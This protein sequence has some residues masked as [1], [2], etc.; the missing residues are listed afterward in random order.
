MAQE[1]YVGGGKYILGKKLGGG[2]FGEIYLGT[3]KHTR[4]FVGVKLVRM[5]PYPALGVQK[6]LQAS[7]AQLRIQDHEAAGRK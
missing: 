1:I 5:R 7:P 2:S 6:D 3:N 4:E